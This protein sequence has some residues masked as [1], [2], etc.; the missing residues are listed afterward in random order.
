MEWVPN[1]C[2]PETEVE[3]WHFVEK[4]SRLVQVSIQYHKDSRLYLVSG[5]GN[6]QYADFLPDDIEAA[7]RYAENAF[8]LSINYR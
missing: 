2:A 7:K 4:E 6:I 3:E 5:K 8:V 1:G